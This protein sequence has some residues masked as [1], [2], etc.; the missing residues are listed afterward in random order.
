MWLHR[1]FRLGCWVG[2]RPRTG[3]M[4]HV[5]SPDNWISAQA[6]RCAAGG[7]EA[8]PEWALSHRFIGP[9]PKNR[10]NAQTLPIGRHSGEKRTRYNSAHTFLR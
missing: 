4:F 7:L 1:G 9:M 3:C 2:H 8:L 5:K 10:R 6:Q